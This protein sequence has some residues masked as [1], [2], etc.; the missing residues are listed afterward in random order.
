MRPMAIPLVVIVLASSLA[1]AQDH[2]KPYG[3]S[4][5]WTASTK[6]L[7]VSAKSAKMAHTLHHRH[8]RR[9]GH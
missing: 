8:R 3:A 4:Q 6:A 5:S 9:M 7:T 2:F 1:L